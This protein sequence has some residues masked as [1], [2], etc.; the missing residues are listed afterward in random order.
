M[1]AWQWI[2]CGVGLTV[3]LAG[4]GWTGYHVG[5]TT[6][7]A[8]FLAAPLATGQDGRVFTYGDVL[9]DMAV[10]VVQQAMK[11]PPAPAPAPAK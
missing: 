11:Q 10:Q 4:V 9:K 3:L 1:K 6:R 8:A 5:R 7:A 2:A